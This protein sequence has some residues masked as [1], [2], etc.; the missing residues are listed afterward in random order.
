MSAKKRRKKTW[1]HCE[2]DD[3]TCPVCG[4]QLCDQE[5]IALSF[6]DEYECPECKTKNTIVGG[7]TFEILTIQ[8]SNAFNAGKETPDPEWKR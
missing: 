2:N 5:S 8:T 4:Y 6:G 7:T 1:V 3:V